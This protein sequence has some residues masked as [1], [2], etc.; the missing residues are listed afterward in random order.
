[1]EN[2]LV[3]GD[4]FKDGV[5]IITEKDLRNKYSTDTGTIFSQENFD[6]WEKRARVYER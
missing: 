3:N 5:G 6:K 1:V 4:F 2:P